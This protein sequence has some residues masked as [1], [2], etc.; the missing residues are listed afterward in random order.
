[1]KFRKILFV[2]SSSS[3]Q[4]GGLD[5]GGREMRVPNLELLMREQ[6]KKPDPLCHL[7]LCIVR[8][9]LDTIID[10]QFDELGRGAATP[11]IA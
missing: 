5:V 3:S 10:R 6:N 2:D 8:Q 9:G 4:C 1:M 11:H 7:R